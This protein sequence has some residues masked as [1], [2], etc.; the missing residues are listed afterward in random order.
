MHQTIT[1]NARKYVLVPVTEYRKLASSG[2]RTP[3]LPPRNSRGNYP[4]LAAAEATIARSI[5]QRRQAAGLTQRALA[6]AAGIRVETLNRAERGLVTP[7][8][9]TLQRLERALQQAQSRPARRA[10]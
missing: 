1:L 8:V 5:I 6:Q 7:D 10:G 9:R 3:P 4:A 2:S